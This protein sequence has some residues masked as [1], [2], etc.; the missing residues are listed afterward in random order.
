MKIF[1]LFLALG[2]LGGCST[3]SHIITGNVRTAISADAVKVYTDAPE[4]YE[5]IGFVTASYAG[6][7]QR[8]MDLAMSELKNQAGKIGANG[9]LLNGAS[10]ASSP[11]YIYN[12]YGGVVV[13]SQTTSIS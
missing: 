3:G 8:A 13:N 10:T 2:L 1:T 12:P 5:K 7:G 6:V 9:V 4:K 11:T